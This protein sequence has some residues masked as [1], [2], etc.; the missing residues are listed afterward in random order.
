MPGS[1]SPPMFTHVR[2]TLTCSTLRESKKSVFFGRALALFDSAVITT[3]RY[4]TPDAFPS[5]SASQ[6][7]QMPSTPARPVFG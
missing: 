2:S 6:S 3:S 1:C 7:V 4:V 5:M